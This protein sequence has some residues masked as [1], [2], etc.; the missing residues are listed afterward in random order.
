MERPGIDR[1]LRIL[2]GA[3]YLFAQA[4]GTSHLRQPTNKQTADGEKR[5]L[6]MR[7]RGRVG[8]PRG[9]GVGRGGAWATFRP[10]RPTSFQRSP[11]K[12]GRMGATATHSLKKRN[13]GRAAN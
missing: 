13:H 5:Q 7:K 3:Q 6:N 12:R 10:Q 1:A 9:G 4:S 8:A 2:K 11:R